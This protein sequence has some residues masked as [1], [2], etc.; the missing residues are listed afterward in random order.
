ME[1]SDTTRL[2]V[3]SGDKVVLQP[4]VPNSISGVTY[5]WSDGS[6]AAT[7]DLGAVKQSGVYNVNIDING[8][9]ETVTYEVF[10]KQNTQSS[11]AP[12]YYLVY[13]VESGKF[14]T[15]N[16]FQQQVTFEAG[17]SL[18]PQKNQVW[19][20]E[21]NNS[22]KH[23]FTSLSD[24]LGLSIVGT[25]TSV[26][27]KTFGIEEPIGLKRYALYSIVG[28]TKNFW[29]VDKNGNLS[30]VAGA[31]PADY[32]F[33]F[34]PVNETLGI[35]DIKSESTISSPVYELSGKKVNGNHPSRKGIYIQKGKKF[36]GR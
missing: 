20:I 3:N 31:S 32:P 22:K 11:L 14:L 21:C 16:G 26:A 19:K 12:A 34:I 33:L 18:S 17:D 35:E 6:T 13:H 8:R 23:S 1:L 24:S 15:S 29:N 9:I 27:V 2:I 5:L 30:I 36:V 4:Y 25:T 7:L 28:T 10:V